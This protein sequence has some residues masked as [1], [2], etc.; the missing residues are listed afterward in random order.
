MITLRIYL[1]M[2]L[3]YAAGSGCVTVNSPL[4]PCPQGPIVLDRA[5][6]QVQA[7]AATPQC[8]PPVERVPTAAPGE[9]V[10]LPG[11]LSVPR[12]DPPAST[13]GAR[14]RRLMA[15]G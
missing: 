2:G 6:P 11:S 5:C 14:S 1:A 12:L 8:P 4:F 9:P 3:S 13:G 7:I 15:G 10:T